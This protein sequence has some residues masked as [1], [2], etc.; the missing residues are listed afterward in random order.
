MFRVQVEVSPGQI[1]DLLSSEVYSFRN[2]SGGPP[3]SAEHS[4]AQPSEAPTPN[5]GEATS[6]GAATSPEPASAASAQLVGAPFSLCY[7][8]HE[9]LYMCH[10]KMEIIRQL[11]LTGCF[12]AF[13]KLRLCLSSCSKVHWL[14]W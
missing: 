3:G 1:A 7:D 14:W 5:G 6:N 8:F 10:Q 11:V 12:P 9:F 4:G 2:S 13:F